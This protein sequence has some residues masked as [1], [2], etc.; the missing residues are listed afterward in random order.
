MTH[1]IHAAMLVLSVAA[2]AFLLCGLDL[3][4]LALACV[5]AV[6]WWRVERE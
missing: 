6:L 1:P 2:F 4:A 3:A 5:G